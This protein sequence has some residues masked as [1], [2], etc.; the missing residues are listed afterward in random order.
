MNVKHLYCSACAKEFEP[1]KLYNLCPCGKPLM[2]AYDLAKAGQ[3]L[4]KEALAGREA[5]LWRYR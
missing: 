4:T 5:T 3:A 1:R 2:V